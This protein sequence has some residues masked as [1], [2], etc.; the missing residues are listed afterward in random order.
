MEDGKMKIKNTFFILL[1]VLLP[2]VFFFK[3][4]LAD[5]GEPSSKP[6]SPKSVIQNLSPASIGDKQLRKAEVIQRT[7]KLQMPF[8]ANEG[9][10]DER[11]MFYANTFGGTVFIT[12]NGEFVYSLP[13]RKNEGADGN[14]HNKSEN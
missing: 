10:T 7:K 2:V 1:V 14:A 12:K 3:I 8:I 4:L 9:Q 11:V 6:I 5:T 13:Q